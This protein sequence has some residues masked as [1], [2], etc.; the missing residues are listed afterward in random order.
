[1]EGEGLWRERLGRGYGGGGVREGE[2]REGLWRGR[3]GRG[4]RGG[5]VMAVS[6]THLTLPTRR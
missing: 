5:R 3:L 1:M 4:C 2:V 6:Y